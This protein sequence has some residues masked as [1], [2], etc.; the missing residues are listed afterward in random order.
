MLKRLISVACV[1][2][3]LGLVPT[4][5]GAV[6]TTRRGIPDWVKPAVNHLVQQGL[7]ER[8]AF[9]AN[10]PMPR[11]EF[12]RIV[13]AAF[14]GGYSRKKGNVT[15]GEVGAALVRALDRMDVASALDS[16]RSPD[17][18]DPK[19]P[20]RFGTE[21]VSRELGLRH[22]RPTDEESMEAAAEDPMRQADVVWAIWRAM[23]APSIYGADALAG[24]RLDS[25]D[26]VRRKVVRFALSL[27]GTPYIWGGE[28]INQTPA[29]YP[30]GAQPAGGVDCSGFIWYVLQQK[31]SSYAPPGRGYEGWSL[32]ERSS[33]QMAKATPKK[34]RLRY[35]QL[36]PGDVLL[37]APNGRDSKAADVYHAGLY[38]GKGWMVHSSGSRAGVSL[39][40]VGPGSWWHD[41]LIWGRRVITD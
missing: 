7:I 39:A 12:K 9:K 41:Q 40:Q 30:Y 36:K 35:G 3:L 18:W 14:G 28:W 16:S 23:T 8:K 38:L 37:F 1:A 26:P 4:G 34:K 2:G 6:E 25:Y 15:A 11:A 21:V 27:A 22:D 5:V 29:G 10:A 19:V 33:S 32:P 31:S 24:F 20:S 13:R 17:G